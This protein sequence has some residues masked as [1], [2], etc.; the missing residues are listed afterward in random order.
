M[1]HL[2]RHNATTFGIAYSMCGR[3]QTTV[4]CHL[5]ALNRSRAA[6]EHFYLAL[7][8]ICFGNAPANTTD[9]LHR[10]R[11]AGRHRRAYGRDDGT[12]APRISGKAAT[13]PARRAGVSRVVGKERRVA[14]RLRF[15]A[16]RQRLARSATFP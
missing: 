15:T 6:S 10:N 1:P 3:P 4:P 11:A 14:A 16:A 5:S 8:G 2:C 12:R 9:Y 13:D 7:T